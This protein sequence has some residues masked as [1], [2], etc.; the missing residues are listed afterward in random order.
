MAVGLGNVINVIRVENAMLMEDEDE[1]LGMKQLV[2]AEKKKKCGGEI[3]RGRG[4]VLS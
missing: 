3:E 2:R 1:F 4:Q